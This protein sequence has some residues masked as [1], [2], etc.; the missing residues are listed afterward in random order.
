MKKDDDGEEEREEE[1]RGGEG[2][3]RWEKGGELRCHRG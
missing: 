2:V 3:N 1:E